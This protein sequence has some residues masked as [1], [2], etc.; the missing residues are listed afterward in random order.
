VLQQMILQAS[1]EGLLLHPLV[2][3][4]LCPVLQYTDDTLIIIRAI[5]EHVANLKAVLDS[6]SAA[7]RAPSSLLKLTS[8]Q[9]LT[10]PPPLAV[11]SPPFPRPTSAFRS[12][13]ISFALQTSLPLWPRAT[14]GFLVGEVAAFPLGAPASRQLGPDGHACSRHECWHSS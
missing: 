13:L 3:D 2:D 6:F 12:P 14:C 11:L 10:W 9:P 8:N 1:R 7:T 5:P 4:M